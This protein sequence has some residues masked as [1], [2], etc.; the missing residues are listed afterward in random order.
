QAAD[1]ALDLRTQLDSSLFRNVLMNVVRN[2]VEANPGRRGG[3]GIHVSHTEKW[4]EVA[5]SNDGDPVPANLAARIFDPYVSGKGGKDNMGL[6][7]AIVRKIII[8]HGGDI[9]Y[10]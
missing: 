8:E 1:S 3:F 9:T 7:L 2:A 5:L 4:G 6:G 10:A